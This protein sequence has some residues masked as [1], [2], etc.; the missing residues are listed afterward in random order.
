MA[1]VGGWL[2]K[3]ASFL[4]K[5]EKALSMIEQCPPHLFQHVVPEYEMSLKQ[6]LKLY[7]R[8]EAIAVRLD[9][10]KEKGSDEN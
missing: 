6:F 3:P 4:T 10:L 5:A 8:I 2:R 9:Q 1:A 7:T